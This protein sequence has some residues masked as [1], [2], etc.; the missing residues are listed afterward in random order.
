M[1]RNERP[2]TD[3][4]G[5]V[6]S[7]R[8]LAAVLAVLLALSFIPTGDGYLLETILS[9]AGLGKINGSAARYIEEQKETAFAGFLVLSGIK[10][11]LALVKSSEVGFGVHIRIGNLAVAAYDFV[12]FG[13][14]V[15]LA[16]TA[17]F[18]MAQFF[19]D[20]A[21]RVDIAFLWAALGFATL[22]V[23]GRM[24]LPEW[25][26]TGRF[27]SRTGRVAAVIALVFYLGFPLIFV[28]A[29]WVSAGITGPPI[30]EANQVYEDMERILPGIL[31]PDESARDP[32]TG[33]TPPDNGVR[34]ET[35]TV[36]FQP[37]SAMGEQGSP[38]VL[39]GM[40]EVEQAAEFF[41]VGLPE[42]ERGAFAR[43][44]S[45]VRES[46]IPL[47]RLRALSDF[48]A[49]KAASLASSVL[50]QAAAYLFDIVVLPLLSLLAL[51][52][53][54]RYLITVNLGP[55]G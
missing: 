1:G 22:A 32:L 44:W 21:G 47:D 38:V 41:Q 35:A 54:A 52:L 43:F 29:G 37:G 5:F 33:G 16:A 39:Y 40:P 15:L 8:F 36:P 19:L 9:K 34:V 23:L 30:E 28:G 2:M 31:S 18:T 48:A 17:Y 10:V 11:A 14:K 24:F 20:L 55:A 26:R 42:G 49:E 13:W 4:R 7:N 50:H 25:R 46:I 6:T 27:L 45:G 3:I 51:Y 53:G 12:D